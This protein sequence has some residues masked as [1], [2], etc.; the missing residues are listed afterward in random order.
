M[1]SSSQ[2]FPVTL[3]KADFW[4]GYSEDVYLLKPNNSPDKTAEFAVTRLGHPDVCRNGLSRGEPVI[5][6]HGLYENRTVW[7]YEQHEMLC[8]LLNAGADVWIMEMRGHGL[9]KV[10]HDSRQNH[11]R[12]YAR[13]DLPALQQFIREQNPAR[14]TWLAREQ[15]AVSLLLALEYGL[16]DKQSEDRFFVTRLGDLLR[17]DFPGLILARSL[18]NRKSR[19]I[20]AGRNEYESRLAIKQIWRQKSWFTGPKSLDG[21]TPLLKSMQQNPLSN[22]FYLSDMNDPHQRKLISRAGFTVVEEK[23]FSE[24]LLVSL[25]TNPVH[26][27]G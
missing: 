24:A 10:N 4:E 18:F 14:Q 9:S 11:W 16:L 5:L 26:K 22:L 1:K 8:Q 27:V 20:P 19:F 6:L 21:K 15:G 12:N 17:R 25:I 3:F 2:L 7:M 23:A 13:Y